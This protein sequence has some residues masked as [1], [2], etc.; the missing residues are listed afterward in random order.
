MIRS[1]SSG[2]VQ[3]DRAKTQSLDSL[4]VRTEQTLQSIFQV[5]HLLSLSFQ[6][7]SYHVHWHQR[8]LYSQLPLPESLCD[9]QLAD[10]HAEAGPCSKLF[11][12]NRLPKH[13]YQ[14]S[15]K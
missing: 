8:P 9:R 15:P 1:S 13:K 5:S 12:N 4:D 10:N 11:G 3:V 7:A 2:E 14:K 6:A